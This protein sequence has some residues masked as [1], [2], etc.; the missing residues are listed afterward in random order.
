MKTTT[1]MSLILNI[2]TSGHNCSVAVHKN[3]KLVKQEVNTIG[4][5]H[6]EVL[7][8][9]IAETLQTVGGRID[10]VAISAGPGSYTGLRIGASGAKGLC[11]ALGIPLIAINTLEIY[12]QTLYDNQL[13][14]D[15]IIIP[16][17]DAR[18]E[19]IYFAAFE[20]KKTTIPAQAKVLDDQFYT[21]FNSQKKHFLTGDGAEKTFHYLKDKLSLEKI[22]LKAIEANYMGSL[23]LEKFN[24]KKFA[25]IAYFE[26]DYLKPF[27][28]TAKSGL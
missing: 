8:V 4:L 26:P 16:C 12:A 18:R 9:M 17:I 10:A 13:A 11:Y 24:S 6:A 28:S 14:K 23:S 22:E 5:K 7:H 2:D 27:F 21:L 1:N 3:G 20:N 15:E 25:D 19:E